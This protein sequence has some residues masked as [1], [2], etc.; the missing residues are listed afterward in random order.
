M[1]S[2][3]TLEITAQNKRGWLDVTGTAVSWLCLIH[4][5]ALP[6]FIS[7]LPL[8]G[9]SFLLEETTERVFIG[10]SAA[11]AGLSLLPAYFRKHGKLHSIF[12]AAAGIGLILVTHLLFEE[13]LTA[14]I[15]FL[16]S[17][18]ILISAAHLLNRRLCRTCEIC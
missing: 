18:A 3:Q 12:L 7:I 17:G 16:A 8:I 2:E 11:V 9:L 15:I 13:N 1:N 4:C 5:V 6:F 10:I 14:K